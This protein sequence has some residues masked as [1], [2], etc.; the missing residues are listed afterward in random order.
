MQSAHGITQPT[1]KGI[2]MRPRKHTANKLGPSQTTKFAVRA[3][4]WSNTRGSPLDSVSKGCSLVSQNWG[5]GGFKTPRQGAFHQVGFARAGSSCHIHSQPAGLA[6]GVPIRSG[7]CL[8][9]YDKIK[10]RQLDANKLK[11]DGQ[12]KEQTIPRSIHRYYSKSS[13]AQMSAG[14]KT[15]KQTTRCMKGTEHPGGSDELHIRLSSSNGCAHKFAEWALGFVEQLSDYCN[16]F[17][18]TGLQR[19]LRN[20]P[21]DAYSTR[22]LTDMSSVRRSGTFLQY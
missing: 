18:R 7:C 17:W 13:A 6:P 2:Y 8:T 3:L 10:F 15:Q 11:V 9:V 1:A 14:E 21:M 19:T 22:A 16:F 4:Y 20:S 5:R 12:T